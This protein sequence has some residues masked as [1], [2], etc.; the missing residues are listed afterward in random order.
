MIL[1]HVVIYMCSF[2]AP[3]RK[4][5]HPASTYFAVPWSSLPVCLTKTPGRTAKNFACRD[6][7]E[8]CKQLLF[9]S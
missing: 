2:S 3:I 7:E 9:R 1:S 8:C 6:V 4:V 5:T